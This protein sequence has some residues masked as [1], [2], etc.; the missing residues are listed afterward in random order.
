MD[1]V[2]IAVVVGLLTRN[3]RETVGTT[4]AAGLDELKEE[5]TA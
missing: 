5:A 1:V 4:E 2:L 3:I